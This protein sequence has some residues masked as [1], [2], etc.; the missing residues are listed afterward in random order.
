MSSP[1]R[2]MPNGRLNTPEF[3]KEVALYYLSHEHMT[4]TAVAE[5]FGIARPTVREWVRIFADQYPTMEAV[6]KALVEQ[7]TEKISAIPT[8][9]E[10]TDNDG[11]KDACVS[12]DAEIARLKAELRRQQIR[13][14]A[15]EELIKVAESKFNI[16]IRKKAGAKQ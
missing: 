5:K 16:P 1:L 9:H 8:E 7:E 4:M 3:K 10:A 6:N 13:A 14:E 12:K 15:Y 2:V 11:G